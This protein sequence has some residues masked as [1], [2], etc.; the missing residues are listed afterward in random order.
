MKISKS[1]LNLWINNYEKN[2]NLNML[3]EDIVNILHHKK[4]QNKELI[5]IIYIIKQFIDGKYKLE[6][7]NNLN[8]EFISK[9]ISF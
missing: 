2:I 5:K 9:I 6:K 3:T 8:K 7:Y 1:F 4:D